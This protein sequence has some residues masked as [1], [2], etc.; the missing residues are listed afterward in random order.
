MLL[1]TNGGAGVLNPFM[2]ALITMGGTHGTIAPVRTSFVRVYW[3]I[4]SAVDYK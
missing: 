4:H 1:F 2:R 3:T